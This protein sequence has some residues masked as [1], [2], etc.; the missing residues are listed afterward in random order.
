M[1]LIVHITVTLFMGKTIT[2]NL[3]V[4]CFLSLTFLFANFSLGFEFDDVCEF[5]ADCWTRAAEHWT[6]LL[7]LKETSN[8]KVIYVTYRITSNMRGMNRTYILCMHLFKNT[9]CLS[10]KKLGLLATQIFSSTVIS[11]WLNC[12]FRFEVVRTLF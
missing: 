8:P 2:T 1:F 11:K 5:A 4:S 3:F 12:S 6:Y 7:N 10:K 9:L